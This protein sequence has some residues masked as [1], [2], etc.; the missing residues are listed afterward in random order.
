MEESS[1]IPNINLEGSK[2]NDVYEINFNVIIAIVIVVVVAVGGFL[3]WKSNSTKNA[4]VAPTPT[5]TEVVTMAPTSA[6]T[7]TPTPT[8]V[9]S[10]VTPTLNAKQ[11]VKIQVLN[12]TGAV[13][14]A[15]FLKSKLVAAGFATIDTGNGDSTSADAN[16][17]V[18]YYDTFP[19]IYKID[20]TSL[21]NDSYAS[22][23][24]TTSV[25]T[26][27]YDAVIV[28]GKKK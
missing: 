16:T 26:S 5:P 8:I 11:K 4:A 9:G 12:G 20:L 27:K 24:A 17:M 2:S 1:T 21:L 23:S 10:T 6:P 7:L 19:S 25:D 3:F 14:D 18:T 22:V 13:G 15:A 28:T